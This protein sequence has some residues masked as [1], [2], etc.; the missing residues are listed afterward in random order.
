MSLFASFYSG[1]PENNPVQILV[2][3]EAS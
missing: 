1:R 2:Y 3:Y